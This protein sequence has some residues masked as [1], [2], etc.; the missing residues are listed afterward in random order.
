MEEMPE[1][2]N[3]SRLAIHRPKKAAAVTLRVWYGWR[4]RDIASF[5]GCCIATAQLHYRGGLQYLR[6]AR[7]NPSRWEQLGPPLKSQMLGYRHRW[8]SR[9][10]LPVMPEGYPGRL[11]RMVDGYYKAHPERLIGI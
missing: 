8:E 3:V 2:A 9:R 4:W 11:E 7:D 6:Q 1:W 10:E 5:L